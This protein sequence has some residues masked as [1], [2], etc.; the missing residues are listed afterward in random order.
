MDGVI[1]TLDAALAKQGETVKSIETWKAEMPTEAEMLPRDKYTMFDRKEKRYRK[2]IHS[3]FSH[4]FG[5]GL[6]IPSALEAYTGP[7]RIHSKRRAMFD[8]FWALANFKS[9]ELPKW[10]RVSQRVNPP[11]Y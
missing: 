3:E 5:K 8:R 2:G 6:G 4:L 9:T 1:A 10:T 7:E 11:G